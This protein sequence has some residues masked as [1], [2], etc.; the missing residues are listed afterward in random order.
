MGVMIIT[1][2][3]KI[4]SMGYMYTLDRFSGIK[5]SENQHIQLSL[6]PRLHPINPNFSGGAWGQT[7]YR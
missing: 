5:A 6:V 3:M 7:T 1:V 4:F 2:A